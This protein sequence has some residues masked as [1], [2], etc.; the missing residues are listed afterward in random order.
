MAKDKNIDVHIKSGKNMMYEASH[1]ITI[2]NKNKEEEIEKIAWKLFQDKLQLRF[3]RELSPE[4]KKEITSKPTYD[5]YRKEATNIYEKKIRKAIKA[6]N[7]KKYPIIDVP[8]SGKSGWM[9][10]AYTLCFVYSKYNGNFVLRGYMR[11]VEEYLKK[12]YTHY[13]YNLSLWYNG[14]NRDIWGFWKKD[15]HISQPDGY[16]SKHTKPQNKYWVG[17]F[18]SCNLSEAENENREEERLKFKRL[19]KKWIPEFDKF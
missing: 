16:F 19:P 8:A 12:N 9:G 3:K 13:F 18:T 14:D 2:P 15:I 17:R 11:E 7:N 4:E 1:I 6:Q 5:Y 10:G